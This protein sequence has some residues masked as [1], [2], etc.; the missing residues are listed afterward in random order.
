MLISWLRGE[1]PGG[2]FHFRVNASVV[3][4]RFTSSKGRCSWYQYRN[5]K[6][7][8][9]AACHLLNGEVDYFTKSKGVTD[10]EAECFVAR[11]VKE[12][13]KAFENVSRDGASWDTSAKNASQS[14]R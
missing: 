11:C 4:A 7:Y 13:E 8:P 1:D 2:E 12:D 5:A 3:G 9:I 14:R 10:S 6:G